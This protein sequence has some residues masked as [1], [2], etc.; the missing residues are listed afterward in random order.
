MRLCNSL[1]MASL[2]FLDRGTGER[3]KYKR[4]PPQGIVR[5]TQA[6]LESGRATARS[7]ANTGTCVPALFR[8]FPR[9][10]RSHVTLTWTLHQTG[11]YRQTELSGAGA[12]RTARI[13]I[14]GSKCGRNYMRIRTLSR[15]RVKPI[16]DVDCI[17]Q[18][19]DQAISL[20]HESRSTFWIPG[21]MY[22]ISATHYVG[23]SDCSSRLRRR[24]SDTYPI[25]DVHDAPARC[26][27][28][29]ERSS[30][31]RVRHF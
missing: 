2:W 3:K 17:C 19:R 9:I 18:R 7:E 4:P 16:P 28:F 23:P 31:P 29:G 11:V 8:T 10:N 25:M 21:G 15:R 26:D 6:E 24:F 27:H 12:V 30:H 14:I 1:R 13:W 5:P 22:E 20:A